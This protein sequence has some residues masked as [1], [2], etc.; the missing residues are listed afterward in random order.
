MHKQMALWVS[1]VTDA[2]GFL[3][4]LYVALKDPDQ[5]KR[6]E[7]AGAFA[8][9][10]SRGRGRVS[11]LITRPWIGLKPVQSERLAWIGVIQG[12]LGLN[13]LV[14]LA[15]SNEGGGSPSSL[16]ARLNQELDSAVRGFATAFPREMVEADLDCL[17][18][19]VIN[20]AVEVAE[21]AWHDVRQPGE[22]HVQLREVLREDWLRTIR[23]SLLQRLDQH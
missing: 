9:E 7:S 14:A 13:I 17:C 10:R 6:A 2:T 12:L 4:R 8:R 1:Q 22:G 15:N 20:E 21:A 5:R 23:P 18:L 11:V 3:K 19:Q 16:H